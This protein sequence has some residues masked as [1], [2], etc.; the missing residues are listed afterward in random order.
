MDCP[1][2]TP[3]IITRP[4]LSIEAVIHEPNNNPIS[5]DCV[6]QYPIIKEIMSK[7]DPKHRRAP[8]KR[9]KNSTKDIAPPRI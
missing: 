1:P 8:V 3:M 9:K 5:N 4:I 6:T 7:T 2:K